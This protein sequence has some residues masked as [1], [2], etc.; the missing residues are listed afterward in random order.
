MKKSILVIDELSNHKDVKPFN[1]RFAKLLV[2]KLKL[3]HEINI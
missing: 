3:E 2:D 1:H